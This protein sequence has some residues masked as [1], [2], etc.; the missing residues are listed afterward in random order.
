MTTH[1]KGLTIERWSGMPFVEQ[2]GNVGS[3]VERT[4]SWRAKKN[5]HYSQMAFE[6]ALEL[7]DL[8]RKDPKN[9]SKLKE[10]GRVRECLVD[11]FMY[12]NEYGSTEE[13]WKKY[14]YNFAYAARKNR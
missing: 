2:M 3:E 11:Y 8:T 6:R 14:F 7:L 4:I 5:E 1:H 12:F 10:L 13:S 9:A